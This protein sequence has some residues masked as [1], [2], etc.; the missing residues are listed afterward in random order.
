MTSMTEASDFAP[1]AALLEAARI[2]AT[3][4]L[5][6][7]EGEAVLIVANP[8]RESFA[9]AS[10]M[11]DAAVAAGARTTLILQPVKNQTDYTEEAVIAAFESRPDVFVSLSAEKL[12]K[13][14][15]G[16]RTPYEWNGVDYDNI[17]HYQLHGA[18][19]LR[20]F[21][22][23]GATRA[24]FKKTVP[25]DYEALRIRCRAVAEALAGGLY[26]RVTNAGGTDIHIGLKGRAPKVDD[27][28]FSS[29]G[30][31]GN[32]PAGEVFVSP[33]LGLSE[34]LVVFDGS[35]AAIKGDILIREPIRCRVEG[36]F[37]VEVTGG[38]EA[39]A[40]RA[41]LDTGEEAARK[42]GREGALPPD[43]VEA[44]AR[45][46]RN[47]GELGIGLNPAAAVVGNMLEDEKAFRT[48]HFAIGA[49]YDEDA[50][51]LIHLDGLVSRPTIVVVGA[52]GRETV[53][54]K[55]GELVV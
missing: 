28:D 25:I 10:A 16:I 6:L 45:N 47:L 12:G 54:E 15:S 19:T 11:Y 26:A 8:E 42:L 21:W 33:Q 14:R 29:P 22:S 40:L 18:K 31:G 32:L 13:D 38:E 48:C 49:N 53:I 17:F 46:A 23:P 24:M 36:G 30:S 39:A 20:A 4:S 50:P 3:I 51:S 9:I 7:R 37:V 43:K 2:A 52:K 1:D 34:G 5:K 55:D 27:G 41:S 35:I 44:Y